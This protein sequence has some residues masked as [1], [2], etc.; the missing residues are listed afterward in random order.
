M[1]PECL[2]DI[3]QDKSIL[4]VGVGIMEDAK[5]LLHDYKM[6]VR[7]CV[8]LRTF[9]FR[10]RPQLKRCITGSLAD[11]SYEILGKEMDKSLD[12]RCGNWEAVDFSDVQISYAAEDAVS[13]VQIFVSVALNKLDFNEEDLRSGDNWV[14]V[15]S[16]CQGIIDVKFRQEGGKKNNPRKG[17]AVAKSKK[18]NEVKHVSKAYSARRGPLYDNCQLLAPDG[19]LLCTCDRRKAEWYVHKDIGEVVHDDQPYTVRLKF[20]PSGRPGS[21]RNY[22]LTEKENRCVVCGAVDSYI[23]KNVVPH[24]YRKYF[25]RR[26]KEHS[27][28]DVVL[29]CFACHQLSSNLD[30]P[31]RQHY[32]DLCDAPLP[33]HTHNRYHENITV[34]KIRSAARALKFNRG[35]LPEARKLEL[36]EYIQ[37]YCSIDDVND[38]VIEECIK[39]DSKVT[40]DGYIPH[41]YKVVEVV[42][43]SEG[44]LIEFEKAW[45]QHFLNTMQPKF[46]PELWSVDH[47]TVS[48]GEHTN[49]RKYGSEE[50]DIIQVKSHDNECSSHSNN[51]F[52][53]DL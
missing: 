35:K 11:L 47:R 40:N 31:M 22:Y 2:I 34:V 30:A 43:Q 12:V 5:K 18:P 44:G 51:E 50:D 6:L 48:A 3:L 4:K 1:L 17:N 15:L 26:L 27:S 42:R 52:E 25:P 8:D 16:L 21:E 19:Q 24:E 20:E 23:R 49:R 37:N 7:G 28:H 13:S 53:T 29:L 33:S 36:E 14:R 10:H 46:L 32:A 41:G 39:L 9:T 45:R 38:E